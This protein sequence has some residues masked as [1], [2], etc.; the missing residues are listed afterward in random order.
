MARLFPWTYLKCE[1]GCEY[2][3][4]Q[5]AVLGKD[6][7]NFGSSVTNLASKNHT[8]GTGPQTLIP[9]QFSFKWFNVALFLFESAQR[10]AEHL[11]RF[12]GQVSEKLDH[13][14]GKVHFS[15]ASRA[16]RG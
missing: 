6:A 2:L 14:R 11:S 16:E 1:G 5:R 4:N 7:I 12:R 9:R 10:K 3:V 8:V 15:H 13:L